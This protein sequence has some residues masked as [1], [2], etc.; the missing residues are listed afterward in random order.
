MPLDV[1]RIWNACGEA[2]DSFTTASDSFADNLERPAIRQLIGNIDGARLLD[3]GC[4]SGT[5]SVSFAEQGG[6]VVAFDLSATMI[7]LAQER[8]HRCG[9]EV[10]FRVA[11]IREPLPFGDAEF[12]VVFTATALHYV[13]DIGEF[14]KEVARV[15]KPSARLIAS[16]LHPMSTAQFPLAGSEQV[17]VPDPWEGWYF[18]SP[19]RSIETPWL[20]FG[21]VSTEGRR[22]FCHHHTLA[23]YFSALKSACLSITDMLEPAPSSE[24]A[25]KNASRYDQ[26]IRVPVFLIFKAEKI[27]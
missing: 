2:F 17:D 25:L 15:M 4:G 24:F 10:D 13:E 21:A 5:Y 18:G 19:H 23:D 3:L 20:G 26:A 6:Q 1:K 22:I 9:V 7:S 12:D 16:V 11:D 8:A 27:T 14:M